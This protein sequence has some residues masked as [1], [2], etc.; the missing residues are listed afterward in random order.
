MPMSHTDVDVMLAQRG[1]SP[2]VNALLVEA[3]SDD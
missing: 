2:I 1:W 3:V